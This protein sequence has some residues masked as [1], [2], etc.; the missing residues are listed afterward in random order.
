LK[1][2][3]SPSIPL[4]T[5]VDSAPPGVQPEYTDVLGE[6]GISSIFRGTAVTK[7]RGVAAAA[8]WIGDKLVVFPV[9]DKLRVISW[10]TRWETERDAVE[11]ET[12]YREYLGIVSQRDV[13]AGAGEL[14]RTRS[15]TITRHGSSVSVVVKTVA[16]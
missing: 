13:G 3:F 16:S 6:F 4:D 7:E 15:V 12:L 9:R 2:S 8:G 11:F 14:S 1:G 10:L 5:E